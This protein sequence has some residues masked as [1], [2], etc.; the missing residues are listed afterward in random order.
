MGQHFVPQR[1]LR[2][3][4]AP[5]NPGFIWVHD[6]RGG[7]P[8]LAEIAEVAQSKGFYNPETEKVL[9]NEVEAPANSVIQKLVKESSITAT[10]RLQLAFYIGVMMKRVPAHRKRA[11]EMIPGVLED[12][13]AELRS[14]LRSLAKEVNVD[15]DVIV[16]R[17]K[18]ADAVEEKFRRQPPTNVLEQIREPWPSPA[19]VQLLFNMTWRILAA[20]GPQYFIT[21]DNPA[22][23]FRGHGLQNDISELS[24]PLST[25]HALH[26][27]WQRAATNLI[28][29]KASQALVREMNRRLASDAKRLAFYHEPAPWLLKILR[30]DSHYLSSIRW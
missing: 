7:S 1:Y 19:V 30:K 11:M 18:E 10:E 6:K 12:V 29:V 9:A 28:I 22:F 14:K 24:F 4:Q 20:A 23:F 8:R 25:T 17:L 15:P 13:V 2:N 3:F 26:G 16:K 27:S 5:K 21:T